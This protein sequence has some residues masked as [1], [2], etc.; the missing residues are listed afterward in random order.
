MPSI[1]LTIPVKYRLLGIR[2]FFYF[3]QKEI[4]NKTETKKKIR[5]GMVS[6]ENVC[7]FT[8]LTVINIIFTPILLFFNCLERFGPIQRNCIELVFRSIFDFIERN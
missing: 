2:V 3:E 1:F 4:N 6:K 8:Q 5:S 7:L